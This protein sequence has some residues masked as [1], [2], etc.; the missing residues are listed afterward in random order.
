METGDK[1]L[2]ELLDELDSTV[3]GSDRLHDSKTLKVFEYYIDRWKRESK[4][5]AEHVK[6]MEKFEE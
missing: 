6:E 4:S 1:Y 5:T 3:F 2:D